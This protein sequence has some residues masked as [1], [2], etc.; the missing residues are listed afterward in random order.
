MALA[1]QVPLYFP[2]PRWLHMRILF[3]EPPRRIWPFMNFEDNY[4]TK[5]AYLCLAA[6]LRANGF[7]KVEILDC[8]PLRMGWKGLATELQLRRPDV[9]AVGENHALYADEAHRC[10]A[11]AKELLPQ[12]ITVAGGGHFTNLADSYLGGPQTARSAAAPPWLPPLAKGIIDYVVKGEGDIT[13]VEL[14]QHLVDHPNS[15][16]TQV[17]GLAF[18]LDDTIHHTATRPL[19]DDLDSLPIP[20]Y[21]LLPMDRYGRARQLFSPGGTTISHSR[22]CAHSCSFCVWWTQMARRSVDDQG[23]EAL[24]PCWRTKSVDRMVEEMDLLAHRYDKKGLVFVDDCFNLDA[25]WNRDFARAVK[26]AGLKTNWF[27]FMRADYL[28]RDH[29]LGNLAELVEAGLAHVSIGAE[30]VEDDA[31]T[32]FNKRNYT[33]QTTRKAFSILKQHHPSVFRQATFIVGVPEETPA[34]MRRQ[35]AFAK[36]LDL[37]YPGFHPLTPVPGT[38]LW[39]QAIADGVIEA[40]TF[41]QF[42]WATP[43]VPSRHMSRR[44]IETELIAMEKA[45]VTLPWLLRGLSSRSQYKRRMYQWFVKVSAR[46]SLDLLHG[47]VTR[48]QGP[49]VPLIKPDWYDE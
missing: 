45:Y 36:E 24:R 8:M 4:L 32:L 1:H 10:F 5:Q 35:L 42:D 7:P 46:M 12:V 25:T 26:G 27:A 44:E 9:V 13:A 2:A 39:D 37:D 19:I 41:D 28:L 15:P 20:A 22:G 18:A 16:P 11:L 6:N 48:S 33:A 3:V 34:S 23:K 38:A 29:E 47:M 21:D 17:P 31:L 14:M 40:D 30:R 49:L 43:V